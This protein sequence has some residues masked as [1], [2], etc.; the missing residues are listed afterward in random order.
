MRSQ[1]AIYS[2]TRTCTV[3]IWFGS[4]EWWGGW[5]GAGCLIDQ[6]VTVHITSRWRING[7]TLNFHIKIR[8]RMTRYD[9]VRLGFT[10]ILQLVSLIYTSKQLLGLY[11]WNIE[12]LHVWICIRHQVY[13]QVD[14]SVHSS[15]PYVHAP[16]PLMRFASGFSPTCRRAGH[17]REPH[18][19]GRSE[20]RACWPTW[21]DHHCMQYMHACCSSLL[22]SIMN[23][24]FHPK[25]A[26]PSTRPIQS[27]CVM[28]VRLHHFY[29]ELLLRCSLQTLAHRRPNLLIPSLGGP[30]TGLNLPLRLCW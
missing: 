27:P 16:L 18:C 3:E 15:G 26:V 22:Q 5:F 28:L 12:L 19:A 7:S 6:L 17:T 25:W 8:I 20:R 13:I 9:A 11:C 30:G 2:L 4:I 10:L 1:A 29:F 21:T 23:S 14:G 24:W